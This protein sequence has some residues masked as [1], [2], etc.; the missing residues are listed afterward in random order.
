[1][2]DT[3]T[4]TIGM[5]VLTVIAIIALIAVAV[6]AIQAMRYQDHEDNNGI[7]PDVYI[8]T[9]PSGGTNY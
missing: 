7:L 8:Q 5:M 3:E 1:M 4:S 9:S 6:I 2:A